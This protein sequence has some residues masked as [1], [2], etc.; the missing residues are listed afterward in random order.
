MSDLLSYSIMNTTKAPSASPVA[1]SA[2]SLATPRDSAPSLP[3]PQ[4]SK[5]TTLPPIAA[6]DNY[7][8]TTRFYNSPQKESSSSLHGLGLLSTM[9][10]RAPSVTPPS[11]ALLAPSATS[12]GVGATV[13]RSPSTSS[14][15]SASSVPSAP[16]TPNLRGPSPHSS[17][18]MAAPQSALMASPS[19]SSSGAAPR[20]RR[21]RLGPS[22]DSCRA[23]KVKCDA[24]VVIIAKSPADGGALAEFDLSPADHEAVLAGAPVAVGD[25]ATLVLSHGKLIKFKVCK[26]CAVK[27]LGCCFSKGFTKEDIMMNNKRR[28]DGAA[29]ASASPVSVVAAKKL[30]PAK[31]AKKRAPAASVTI[32]SLTSALMAADSVSVVSAPAPAL[33]LPSTRKSSCFSCRKRKVKCA[34]N[35]AVSKCENCFKKG[36]DCVFDCKP[37][38]ADA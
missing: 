30:R 19:S 21:Q 32:A 38:K 27:G 10:S 11:A 1:S 13:A 33:V 14:S 6:L 29:A 12:L 2:P 4:A 5:T 15:A 36:A 16:S 3:M 23:R 18:S 17:P 28:D 25:D 8:Y 22:C 24:D 20:Q 9:A 34:F 35:P 37:A 31:I 7:C 26:S